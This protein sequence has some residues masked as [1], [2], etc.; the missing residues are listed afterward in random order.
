MIW[1]L[2]FPIFFILVLTDGFISNMLYPAKW[3][4][5]FKDFFLL[6]LTGMFLLN[7]N[8]GKIMDR[9]ISNIGGGTFLSALCFMLICILQIFNPKAPSLA[10]GLLGFKI[11]FIYWLLVPL[12]YAYVRSADDVRTWLK[13]IVGS[14]FFINIFALIQFLIGPAFLIDRFGYG[15]ERAF[16]LA[17]LDY[18]PGVESF[19]RVIGT[20]ASAGQYANF[21]DANTAFAFGLYL[22]S[23]SS[24]EKKIWLAAILLD[25]V[26][27]F[28]S[29]SRGAVLFLLPVFVLFVM[30][31][32]NRSGIVSIVVISALAAMIGL[33]FLGEGVRARFDTLKRTEMIKERTVGF[34]GNI[35]LHYLNEAPMGSGL[36]AASTAARYLDPSQEKHP[37]WVENYPS[38]LQVETGA[39]GVLMFFVFLFS[40]LSKWR[41]SWLPRLNGDHEKPGVAI[42]AYAIG[43]FLFL[44]LFGILD[45][46]PAYIFLWAILGMIIKMVDLSDEA[47]YEAYP[48]ERPY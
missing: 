23:K 12:S 43:Y 42:S 26:G 25:F 32:R 17:A 39:P 13:V 34:T 16:L 5:L 46:T 18:A 9:I 38:K 28:I 33:S 36:G 27:L 10:L 41:F 29:G 48:E 6:G 15:F 19:F 40:L 24:R 37:K 14:S 22:S 20:F 31:S 1:R 21:L 44:S 11:L 2:G 35:F 45:T 30:F 47:Y 4:L 3:P 7:E 8:P